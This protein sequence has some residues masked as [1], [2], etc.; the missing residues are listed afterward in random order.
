[1]GFS[2]SSS[3]LVGGFWHEGFAGGGCGVAFGGTPKLN[4]SAE[5]SSCFSDG[6]GGFGGA[7][8]FALFSSPF[9]AFGGMLLAAVLTLR[10][11]MAAGGGMARAFFKGPSTF[12]SVLTAGLGLGLAATG[13]SIFTVGFGLG[14]CSGAKGLGDAASMEGR[15]WAEDALLGAAFLK[16]LLQ[17]C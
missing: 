7:E 14:G 10:S 1:M 2:A 12:R 9:F 15:E 4:G 6:G 17:K 11:G 8:G 13:G 16:C 5:L 3:I